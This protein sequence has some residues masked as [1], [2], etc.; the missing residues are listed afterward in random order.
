MDAKNENGLTLIDYLQPH[1][2]AAPFINAL[3]QA[4]P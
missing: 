1:K 3:K 4:A 2:K